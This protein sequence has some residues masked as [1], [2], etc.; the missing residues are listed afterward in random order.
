M[1]PWNAEARFW[2]VDEWFELPGREKLEMVHGHPLGPKAVERR[3]GPFRRSLVELRLIEHLGRHVFPSDLGYV[4]PGFGFVGLAGK[5]LHPPDIAFIEKERVPPESAWDGLCPVPPDLAIEVLTFVDYPERVA[6]EVH[7]Y[8]AGG[9]RLL[10]VAHPKGR[11]VA[12]HAPRR[13]RRLLRQDDVLDGEDV[14]PG[15]RMPVDEL[16]GPRVERA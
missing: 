15:F 8:I 11:I 5:A 13:P 4:G 2:T 12:V 7:A 16:F 3:L 10:W 1:N 9:V 6:R 14:L